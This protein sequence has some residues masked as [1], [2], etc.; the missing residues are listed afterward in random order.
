MNSGNDL[1]KVGFEIEVVQFK[2]GETFT[3]VASQLMTKGYM[4]NDGDDWNG[5]HEYGCRCAQVCRHVRGGDVMSPPMVS[6]TYDASLPQTGGEFVTSAIPVEDEFL[7]QFKDIWSTISSRSIWNNTLMNRRAN[8]VASPG[9]HVHCSATDT[10]GKIRATAARGFVHNR[11]MED[12]SSLLTFF[13]PELFRLAVL[14]SN[15]RGMYYRQPLRYVEGDRYG[16]HG[17]F[18][19]R[20]ASPGAAYVEWRLWE[21]EYEDW[22]YVAGV[23]YV[24]AAL[25]RALSNPGTISALMGVAWAYP[26]DESIA[27]K[28]VMSDALGEYLDLSDESRF[29]ALHQLVLENLE[30]DDAGREY[31]DALFRKARR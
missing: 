3:S 18:Q 30:D 16:H 10:Y 21:M 8:D 26:L 14:A 4:P 31:A 29:N 25:T 20:A 6:L 22:D 23:T 15:I 19:V 24:S 5:V 9:F 11:Y 1:V 13:G 12:V 17:A 28:A 2:Q 27:E 7:A